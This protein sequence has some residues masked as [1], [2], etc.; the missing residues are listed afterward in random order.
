MTVTTTAVPAPDDGT[1][2]VEVR[3]PRR[4]G[5][6]AGLVPAAPPGEGTGWSRPVARTWASPAWSRRARSRSF[7]AAWRSE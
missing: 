1:P 7:A 4:G 5:S 6:W 3:R 2:T